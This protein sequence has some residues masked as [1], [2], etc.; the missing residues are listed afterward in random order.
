M[1]LP[2]RHA[3]IDIATCYG[4]DGWGSNPPIPVAEQLMGLRIRILP[5]ALIFVLCVVSKDKKA[6]CRTIKTKNE[7]RMKY[8]IQENKTKILV[9][10]RFSA[11]VQTGPG[12]HPASYTTDTGSLSRD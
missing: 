11:P 1:R 9:R 8:T 7:I 5:G 2:R 12:A 3:G 4:L 6:K 10:V